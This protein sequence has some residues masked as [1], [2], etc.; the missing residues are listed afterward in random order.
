MSRPRWRWGLAAIL[1]GIGVLIGAL[2]SILVARPVQPVSIPPSIAD[3]PLRAHLF[4]PEAAAEIERLHRR[5]IPMNGAAVA[6]YGEGNAILWVSDIWLPIGAWALEQRMT[7]RI[8]TAE[9]PFTITEEREIDGVRV[10]VLEGTGQRHYY[11]HV[12]SR[13]Y[14]LAVDPPLAEAAFQDLL[15]FARQATGF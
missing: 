8:R 4:G 5:R 15:D 12:G 2:L 1:L 14:W 11:F 13:L 10:Y 3:L 9:T 7:Q 6:L